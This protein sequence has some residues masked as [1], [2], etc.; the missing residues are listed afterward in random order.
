M[1]DQELMLSVIVPVYNGSKYVPQ[2]VQSILANNDLV[3]LGIEVILVNDG[4][5]DNTE[6]V[7]REISL[8]QR[9]IVYVQK[10]NGGIASARN[11]GLGLAR[12]RY[13]TF[14]DQDDRLID[15]NGYVQYLQQCLD[16]N[17]DILYTSPYYINDRCEKPQKRTFEDRFIDDVPLIR[18]MAGKLIDAKYLSIDEAPSVSTSVW[19]AFYRKEML[20]DH[21]ITFK[22]F[23]DYEDDWI[24]NIETLMAAERVAMTSRGYYCWVIHGTSESHRTKYI[25]NLLEKRKLWMDWVTDIAK[26]L[27]TDESVIHSYIENVLRPRNIMMCFNNACWKPETDKEEILNEIRQAIGDGGWSIK[28]VSLTKVDE[29]DKLNRLLLL[30]LKHHCINAAYYLNICLF[31]KRFH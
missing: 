29:M 22:V 12:G 30:L 13:I 10:A 21:R 23:I 15:K 31:R 3:K 28:A 9:N 11:F 2:L 14:A 16:G 5:Q 26:K 27:G 8:K 4:S 20:D 25:P 17:L 24:F 19:N 18:K 6:E 7:C 1:T